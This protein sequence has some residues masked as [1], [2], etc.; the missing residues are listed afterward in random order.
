V[1]GDL[2]N[3]HVGNIGDGDVAFGGSVHVNCVRA[4]A[5]QGDDF[6]IFQTVYDVLGNSAS[7]GDYGIG[8]ASGLYELL[9]CLGGNLYDFRAHA[10]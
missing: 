10:T 2:L 1:I 8:I 4:H 9:L 3:E 5:T 6:A 7:P